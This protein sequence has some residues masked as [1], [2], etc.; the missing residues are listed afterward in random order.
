MKQLIERRMTPAGTQRGAA[1][2]VIV[3]VLFLVMAMMA[4]FA[5]RNLMF[6]QRIASNYY[7]AGLSHEVAEA[8]AVAV[9]AW[10]AFGGEWAGGG[11]ACLLFL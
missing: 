6:E 7:R 11:H 8:G 4:A 5:N 2:L 10:R 1:T 3:M 9:V